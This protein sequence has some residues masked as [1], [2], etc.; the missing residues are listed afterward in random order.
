VGVRVV[1]VD[2]R[3]LG[4]GWATVR[5]IGYTV[6]VLTLCTG[7]LLIAAGYKKQGLHDVIAGT[8]VIEIRQAKTVSMTHAVDTRETGLDR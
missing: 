4:I 3:P 7:F 6:S 1:R 8:S 5:F 2:G